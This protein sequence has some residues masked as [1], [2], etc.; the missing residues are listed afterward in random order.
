MII[1][2]F[3]LSEHISSGIGLENCRVAGREEY[4]IIYLEMTLPE[5][6]FVDSSLLK[7]EEN[8]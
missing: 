6:C 4:I 5:Y 8:I 1:V 3:I 7:V 2:Y